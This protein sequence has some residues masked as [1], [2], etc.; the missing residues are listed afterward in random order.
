MRQ[1]PIQMKIDDGPNEAYLF[2]LLFSEH[3]A[4]GDSA[5]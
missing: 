4:T 1:S 5:V 2:K 3:P